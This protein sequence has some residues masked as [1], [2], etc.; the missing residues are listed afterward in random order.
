MPG[1]RWKKPKAD[2]GVVN[3]GGIRTGLAAGEITEKD[4]LSVQP[5]GNM[6]CYLELNGAGLKH[7]IEDIATIEPTSGGFAHFSDNVKLVISGGEKLTKLEINGQPV[8]KDKIYRLAI[9]EFSASGGDNW[10][11]LDN[12]PTFINTGYTDAVVLKEYIQKHSPLKRVDFEPGAGNI[13]RK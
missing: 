1:H 12:N 5:F 9:N 3:G 10:P 6:V 7:F 11:E 13:I 4:I 8:K 2:L